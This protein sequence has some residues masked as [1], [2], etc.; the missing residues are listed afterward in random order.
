MKNKVNLIT[1][2]LIIVIM[3]SQF[4]ISI[5]AATQADKVQV[6]EQISETEKEIKD[7]E[8]NLSQAMKEL[9]ALEGD[10]SE[11]EYNLQKLKTELK[12]LQKEITELE[13]KLEQAT[14]D[15]NEK[16]EQA[17]TRVVAQYKYGNITFLDVLLNSE[18]LTDFLSNYYMVEKIMEADQEFLEELAD[19]KQQIETDKATLEDKKAQVETEKKE[20]ERQNVLLTNK[21]NEKQKRVNTLNAEEAALQQEKE[22]Y[23]AELNRIEED[24]R[25]QAEKEGNTGGSYSGGQLAF[26]CP[27]YR[28]VSSWFGN[29]G[30][31]LAGGSSYHKGIDFAAAKGT[32]IYSS[33]A[34]TVITV[35]TGCTHNYGKSKSCGCGRGYGNY[36]MVSHGG[37]LV[38]VYAHCTDIYV[39]VGTKVSRGQAIATVGSTGA[40]TGHHLHYGVLLNGTYE[41]PAPYIGLEQ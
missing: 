5:Y 20:V 6:Q 32:T 40:S 34:G 8:A 28:R 26:P 1:T 14:T 24:L 12:N 13:A 38:T 22:N 39:S 31:P 29:R 2:I 4:T 7:V 11:V 16:Y 25:R 27:G 23:Y 17:C 15:Y 36:L 10:I 41:D 21:K 30:A 33:E 3:L 37:G 19:K 9:Q 35:I 18:S